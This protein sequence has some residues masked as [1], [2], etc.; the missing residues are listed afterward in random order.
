MSPPPKRHKPISKPGEQLLF[1]PA[2]DD[3]AIAGQQVIAEQIERSHGRLAAAPP[4]HREGH[5]GLR[6]RHDRGDD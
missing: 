6:G 4:V 2:A 1:D 5:R 3:Q